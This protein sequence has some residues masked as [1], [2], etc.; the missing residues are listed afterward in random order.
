MKSGCTSK[1]AEKKRSIE[2]P[3]L[4]NAP[5][6]EE[7]ISHSRASIWRAGAL[8][9]LTLLMIAHVIQWRLTGQ[10]VSPIEPSETMH[11]LQRGAINAGFI[12]FSLAILATLIFGRF[13]C[14]WGCHI[15]ALQD[16]CAWLMQKFGIKPR[17]F[18][19]RLLVYVPLIVALY[20]FVWPTA[21]RFF[22]APPNEPV[23]PPFTNHLI[24]DDFWATFPP[25]A[26]A[27]PFLFICGFMT[28]YF[29]GSK[30]FCTYACPY[31]GVFVLADRLAPGKIRV[32]DACN[33]CGHCT[34]TCTSNVL[35]HA[36]VK[37]YGMVVDPGCMKC[38]DCI[39]VC[40][41]DALYFGFGKPAIAISK[42]AAPKTIAKNYSLTW[43]EEGAAAII[44]FLSFLAV[45]DVY[46]LVPMLMALGIAT[47]TTFLV[48][49]T[50]RL[51]RAKD[52]S[53]YRFNL[54]SSGTIRRAGWA[55]LALALLW[56]GVNAHSGWIHY[57]E[58]VGARTF[59]DLK[60]PDELALARTNPVRWLSAGDQAN[61]AAG[62]K[63]FHAAID[64]GLFVNSA[65]LPK[66]AWMEYLS[67]NTEQA[68][69]ML[70]KAAEHQE[71]QGKALSLYY[72][73]AILNRLGRYD[74]ALAS[75]D[76][77]LGE[78][79]DLIA[80]REERGESLWMLGRKEGAVL[81]WN[82][83]VGRASLPLANNMLAGAAALQGDA[84][85]AAEYEKQADASTPK[86]PL[87]HWMLGLRLQNVGMDE[88]AEKHFGRAIELNPA[89]QRAR[90]PKNR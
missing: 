57:N 40:P 21:Y 50:W 84:E 27:I 82:D 70:G 10:T 59:E 58:S 20:M 77:A 62:K 81:T 7:V 42:A 24:T 54:K 18:R 33:Q 19:S 14:G 4:Q 79:P 30:G 29:L 53:L 11:T 89:F 41:N 71:G 46:Q 26:V 15:V 67:G 69:Q 22:A 75:L 61:I 9:A 68:V 37:Q 88:L 74:Q 55:F 6:R 66:L 51:F 35:V 83:A 13:V 31:G 3:V 25:V 43:P 1:K 87:F 65:A 60:I 63:H 28:V 34:A 23:I 39:S 16:F 12:F 49:R 32:T 56:I 78:R 48:L 45:W 2:L 47:I 86:D 73:G 8:I 64:G 85:T 76:E 44:F 52:L 90:E 72:Q 5:D 36:E 38:M 80:A 17:P